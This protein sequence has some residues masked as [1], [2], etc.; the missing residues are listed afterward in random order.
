[1]TVL[2]KKYGKLARL[3]RYVSVGGTFVFSNIFRLIILGLGQ[4]AQRRISISLGRTERY[5]YVYHLLM[6]FKHGFFLAL[7]FIALS[8]AIA[9]LVFPE[10]TRIYDDL[11]SMLNG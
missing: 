8:V 4:T 1:M 7:A 10:I 5:L 9:M 3:A 11:T 6:G 2:R